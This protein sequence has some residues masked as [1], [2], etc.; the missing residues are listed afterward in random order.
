MAGG[1]FS[2]PSLYFLS[3]RLE[4]TGRWRLGLSRGEIGER[5]WQLARWLGARGGS[6]VDA[7]HRVFDR[8]SSALFEFFKNFHHSNIDQQASERGEGGLGNF[9]ENFLGPFDYM[10]NC[11][12]FTRLATK[13]FWEK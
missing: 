7:A 3:P 9:L 8:R 6:R 5:V 11:L 12:L 4:G 13:V 10:V 1:S 2:S